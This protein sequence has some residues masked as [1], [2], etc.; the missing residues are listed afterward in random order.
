MAIAWVQEFQLQGADR[1]TTNYDAIA[2]RINAQSERP[3]GLILHTAGFDEG[4]GVFRI[5]D[6]WETAA[7]RERFFEDRLNPIL[8]EVMAGA[9]DATP[10]T[11]ESVYELHDVAP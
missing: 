6:V 11:R 9:A 3:P 2:A 5:F 4:S 7:D 10:P 8:Q 1:S